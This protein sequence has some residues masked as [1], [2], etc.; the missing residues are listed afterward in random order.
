[1][2]DS[3]PGRPAMRQVVEIVAAA[4][5]E[6][7]HAT[8]VAKHFNAQNPAYN[9]SW[10]NILLSRAK[11][12]GRVIRT[13]NRE[14]PPGTEDRRLRAYR[15]FITPVGIEYLN[16]EPPP[17]IV[18]WDEPP[19]PR[20]ILGLLVDAGDKGVRGSDLARHFTIRRPPNMPSLGHLGPWSQSL[21][22]RLAW[23]NQIL[24]RFL[25][26]GYARK[27]KAEPSPYYHRVPV[28]RW[29][30]TPEGV[31]YLAD[32]LAEG[33]RKMRD[34]REAAENER[35][36]Q[37]RKKLDNLLTQA[38]VEN[39]PATVT[40]C[41][42]ERVIRELRDAGCTLQDIGDVFGIT[43]ERVR[44]VQMGINVNPCRC[45]ECND[46]QWFEVGDGESQ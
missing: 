35:L 8:E 14:L 26:N 27:G 5:D 13:R 30:V 31:Q 11:C 16:P 19:S 15:W 21:Q 22:R 20:R 12:D 18:P 36:A 38:Y 3:Q 10:T 29:F 28:Y 37:H 39:D 44:Q 25:I 9:L 34:E 43:R 4:G 46:K 32:G 45:P 1:M 33:R 23:T 24:D 6:G 17:V 40:A 41:Q 7:I 2:T 42:R